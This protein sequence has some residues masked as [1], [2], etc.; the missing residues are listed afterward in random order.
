MLVTDGVG[1]EIGLADDGSG[2]SNNTRAHGWRHVRFSAAADACMHFLKLRGAC[3]QACA[4]ARRLN[5][6]HAYE[7]RDRRHVIAR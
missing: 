1:W 4:C 5:Y 7:R 6:M 3:L 2:N